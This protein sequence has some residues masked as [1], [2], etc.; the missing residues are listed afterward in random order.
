MD[1]NPFLKKNS[2]LEYIALTVDRMLDLDPQRRPSLEEAQAAFDGVFHE[3][4][5]QKSNIGI[6]YH[7]G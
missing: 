1:Q 7:R 2:A 4:G 3:V 5:P 6:F